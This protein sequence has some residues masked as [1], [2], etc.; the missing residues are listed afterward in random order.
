MQTDRDQVRTALHHQGSSSQKWLPPPRRGFMRWLVRSFLSLWALAAMGVGLS[1]LK[2]P[3]TGRRRRLVPAGSFSSLEVGHARL[4][5]HGSRPLYVL[6]ISKSEVLAL[7]AVCTHRQCVLGW[8]QE[9]K[10]FACPCHS[11]VFDASGQ[12]ASGLPRRRLEQYRV[13]V[14]RDRIWIHVA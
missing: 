7:S 9:R 6:R 10:V 11:G 2:A 4:V 5:R 12:V 14:Q 3:E 1:Y 13:T 8:S